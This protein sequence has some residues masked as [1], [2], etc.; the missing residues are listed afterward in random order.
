MICERNDS[1]RVSS[2]L[3]PNIRTKSERKK[4]AEQLPLNHR[5]VYTE[6]DYICAKFIRDIRLAPD[7]NNH[8]L[9]E[10]YHVCT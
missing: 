3:R 8:L 4:F 5:N 2:G 7:Q 1:L 10:V 6:Q 9:G